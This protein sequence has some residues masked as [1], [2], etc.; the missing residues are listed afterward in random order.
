MAV[1][2]ATLPPPPRSAQNSSGS[3]SWSARTSRPSA[4]T[5]SAA[6]IVLQ[7]SPWVRISQLRPPPSAYPSTPTFGE[8]PAR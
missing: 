4:V 6:T 5:T 7:A 3:V 8:V 2:A 1:T